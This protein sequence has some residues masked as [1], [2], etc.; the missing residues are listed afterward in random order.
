MRCFQFALILIFTSSLF[1]QRQTAVDFTRV[2]AVLIPDPLEKEITGNVIYEFDILKDVDSVFLNAVNMK[3]TAVEMP[4]EQ[5]RY[6]YENN[7]LILTKKFEAGQSY[8]FMVTY[9]TKPKQTVYFSG[10][11]DT[12]KGNEQ[13]WTQGQG[14]YTSHWLPSFDDM[15]E[16][17]EFDISIIADK[18]HQV[19]SNG[20]LTAV[21]S[22]Y[23]YQQKWN[24]DMHKP[25]SSY[26]AAFVIGDFDKKVIQ[27]KSGISIELYYEPKDSLKVEPTYRYSKEIFDFLEEEI[28][29]A[30]PWQNYKQVPVQD[31]LY[32]GMENTSC[33]IFSNQYVIDSTA[34]VDKNY[35]NVNAHELAH[36][37]FGNLV[38]EESAEHHWLHEGFATYYAYLTEQHLFGDA[39]FYWKLYD[40][41]KT[42]HNL[43]ENGDGEALTNPNA[44]SLTFYEKGAWALVLLKERVGEAAFKTGTKNYLH[45]HQYQNVTISDYLRELEL[46][47]NKDLSSYRKTWLESEEFPWQEVSTFLKQHDHS[48]KLFFKMKETTK[49][50]TVFDEKKLKRFWKKELPT[51]FKKQFMLDYGSQISD[52]SLSKILKSETVEVRQAI[53]LMKTQVSDKLKKDFE[54]LLSD[55][56]YVTQE[57]ALYKLWEAFPEH[58]THYLN[59]TEAIIGLPN[60][61]VRLLWLTLALITPDYEPSKKQVFYQELNTYTAEH[62]H[63][64]VRQQAFQYL[65][66]IQALSDEALKNLIQALDHHVW[67]FKKSC[68]NLIRTLAKNTASKSRLLQLN[69]TLNEQEQKALLKILIE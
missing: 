41:A 5:F 34:F 51:G 49:D 4:K 44:N 25:M 15:N 66:Q 33:T 68:R 45:R 40:T 59:E 2:F 58:R 3:F 63:F 61:N 52:S 42:L 29:V 17:A 22:I 43:S 13:I 21:D 38:T 9:S 37:W 32:A 26:L 14:K 7:L 23:E 30:Y 31:F 8:S 19:I 54:S 57:V 56:S 16:K 24:F 69:K 53:A 64:E 28:G 12:I 55:K 47:S 27:S 36:Q 48:L 1:A 20:Q 39:H 35:V 62:H 60:K 11:D 18:G 65:Y 67:Q 46:A 10:W 50:T 6:N